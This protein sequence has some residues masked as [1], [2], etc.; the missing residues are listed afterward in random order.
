MDS[1]NENL[2]PNPY[3]PPQT[4]SFA[5]VPASSLDTLKQIG[6]ISYVGAPDEQALYEFLRAYGHVGVG[7]LLVVGL[8]LTFVLLTVSLLMGDFLLAFGGIGLLMIV[9]TVSTTSYRRLVFE[10]INPRWNHPTHGVLNAEGVQ[11]ERE[12]STTFFCW[13]WYG[14]AVISDQVVA[15]LPATQTAQPLIITQAMLV[16]LDDWSRL[17]EVA[18]AI[19]IVSDEEP[20]DDRHRQRNLRLLRRTDRVRSIEPPDG[21]IS[22]EGVLDADDFQRVPDRHRWRERPLRSYAV[23]AGLVFFGSFVV[24]AISQSVFQQI[25]FLPAFFLIYAVLAGIGFAFRKMQRRRIKSDVIY[26]LDAF[27]TDSSLVTDFVITTTRIDWSALRLVLR[28]TDV[29]V[30]QRREWIQFIVA[31]RDMFASDTDWQRFN[32]MAD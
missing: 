26:Y 30:L 24:I 12:Q 9:L 32:A 6:P 8:V 4:E 31:R 7:Y 17:L 27:A 15:L 25:A 3:A 5:E 10:N 20:I 19:G 1:P 28:T 14:G 2:H 11:I 21:A 13:D 23:V 18:S 16:K 29:V 22:F